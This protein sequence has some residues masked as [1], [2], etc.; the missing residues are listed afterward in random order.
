MLNALRLEYQPPQGLL[1]HI[2]LNSVNGSKDADM[3]AVNSPTLFQ[4]NGRVFYSRPVTA[5]EM[6]RCLFLSEADEAIIEHST[7]RVECYKMN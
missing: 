7:G 5:E 2:S 6:G 1:A 3:K 4:D